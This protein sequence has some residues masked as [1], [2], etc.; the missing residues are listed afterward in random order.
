METPLDRSATWPYEDGEPGRFSY[1]RADHP[2]GVACE[3]ALGA[4]DRGHGLLYPSG[5]A[6]VTTVV[7][8]M[9]RPGGTI[10]LAEGAYYGHRTLLDHLGPWGVDVVEFDQ[11]GPPPHG[12]DL[13]LV[14]APANPLLTMPDLAAAVA[15]PAPVVCDATVASPLRLRPLEHGCDVA[16]HSATKI[17]S[18]HDDVLAGVTVTRDEELR[19]RLHLTRRLAGIVASAD[20]AW[21]VHRGLESLAA[22][23]DRQEATARILAERLKEHKAVETVRYPGFSFLLSFDVAEG[24]A[25]GRVER[26]VRTIVNATSL[27]G[28]RSKLEARHR[29][30]GDRIPTGLLRLSVGLED[31]ETLWADL[32]RALATA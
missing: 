11:T 22:R 8:T 5:M 12:V 1:A 19:D 6:A 4:L 25:A 27:G 9:L 18:G 28:T 17:L 29:W 7:L 2:T 24:E 15:H 3:E 14:E 31:S 23:L 20:T 10:A 16:L 26:A 13:I 21:L 30:E 32:D